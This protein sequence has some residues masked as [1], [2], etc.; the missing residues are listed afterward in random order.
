MSI[1]AK[2]APIR[3]LFTRTRMLLAAAAIVLAA[4]G[5]TAYYLWKKGDSSAAAQET[6]LQTATVRRGDLKLFATG[7]GTL[8]P[9]AEATFGFSASGQVTEVLVEVGDIVD[10]GAELA[11][12]DDSSAQKQYQQAQRA[13][14]ELTSPAAVA[15]AELAVANAKVTVAEK[16][17][18]LAYLLSPD[19]VYWEEQIA[20][21]EDALE[22]A[23]AEAAASPSADAD[24]KVKNAEKTLLVCKNS[25][26]QAWLDYWNDYVPATFLT[27]VREDHTVK[28]VVISPSDVDVAAARAEY[29]LAKLAL[30]EAE[31]YLTAIT[32]GTIPEG[33][34]GDTIAGLEQARETLA[35]AQ[36]AIDATHLYAPIHGT[37]M[38][39]GFQAGDAAGSNAVI[40]ISD[41]DQPYRLEI[42]LDESDWGNIRAGYP[43]EV[44]FDLLPD[45][46]Y[47][48]K[49]VSVDPSLV[50]SGGGSYIHAYVQL[51]N[52]VDSA[53]PFGTG[54][55]VDVI[56]G[57]ADNALLIPVEA[58][59][60]IAEG[61]Y[62]VFVMV[63]GAPKMR[64]VEIGLQDLLYAEV[65]SGLNE[66]D[67]VTTGITETS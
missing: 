57:Q 1:P 59:H 27:T 31:D 38:S 8:I 41:L 7:T 39:V 42:Y 10:A 54:A 37:V 46:V 11:R 55:T 48:G 17:A 14:D 45:K 18:T 63:D 25:L 22:L 40:T 49:I 26:A 64:Q 65:K 16:R 12:L 62:A 43:A 23:K 56:G 35:A 47:P 3:R 44:T 28:K 60:E 36:D 50:S 6:P 66:G 61:K 24:Q 20:K 34:M 2:S 58:L 53:L 29:T 21:A 52:A 67:I 5:G 9:N 4:A 19:V 51:E 32:T 13:L 15:S 33:A 30:Q